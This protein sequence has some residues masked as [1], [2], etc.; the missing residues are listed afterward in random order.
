MHETSPIQSH[1]RCIVVT[2]FHVR[3][4]GAN[5]VVV[6]P[7]GQKRWYALNAEPLEQ[8]EAFLEPYRAYLSDRLDALETHLDKMNQGR[9]E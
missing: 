7:E 9:T 3:N 4:C 8:V 5:L 2:H 6:R 1:F